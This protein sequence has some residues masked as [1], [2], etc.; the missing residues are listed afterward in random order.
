MIKNLFLVRATIA[1]MLLVL[2]LYA[3][4]NLVSFVEKKV[5]T[6]AEVLTETQELTLA[7]T[8]PELPAP[9]LTPD[10]QIPA[11]QE[12]PKEEK[13]QALILGAKN[14][15]TF[16]EVVT[17]E[18]V[19]KLQ[20]A[21]LDMSNALPSDA[22]IYLV[23]D[24]PGGSVTAGRL[25]VDTINSV[26]QKVKTLTIFAASMAFHIVQ[27]ADERL[28]LPSGT[29]MSHRAKL[30]G[31][32]GEIP[33]ELETRINHLMRQL[34]VMDQTVSQRMSMNL[35][36]YQ[37][38]IRDEYWVTGKD[39]VKARA[40]DKVVLARCGKDLLAGTETVQM[41]LFIVQA[42]V[43][44]SKCPL[45]TYPLD[46]KIKGLEGKS[47]AEKESSTRYLNL[48]LRNKKAFAKEFIMGARSLDYL[49]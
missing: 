35:K 16:R 27:N 41:D 20:K 47:A 9:T 25:L 5:G 34:Q 11:K 3:M 39:A 21:L 26:P 17:D 38:M 44:F 48:L 37:E 28:I 23:I 6:T 40:A 32:G 36:D 12:S 19:S 2:S 1:S 45:I 14:T 42:D 8:G 31:A 4:T 13:V 46:I 15:L 18:S 24:S 7:S 22:T 29:L 49:K 43:K 33:G 10:V 30:S